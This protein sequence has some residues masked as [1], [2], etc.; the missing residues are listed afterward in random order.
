[1]ATLLESFCG[2]DQLL[3]ELPP[4]DVIEDQLTNIWA[5]LLGVCTVDTNDD[6][7]D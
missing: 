2:L 7:F 5:S 3:R 6:F 1:L 4:L